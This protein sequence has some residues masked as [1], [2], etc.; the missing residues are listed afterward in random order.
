MLEKINF[1]YDTLDFDNKEPYRVYLDRKKLA[2]TASY[3][4][5]EEKTTFDISKEYN[6]SVLDIT[7]VGLALPDGTYKDLQILNNKVS[8]YGDW[9]T[10]NVVM[11]VPYLFKATLSPIY[12]RKA[13][14]NGSTEAVTNGRLQLRNIKLNYS[15]T[16]GFVVN[17]VMSTGKT[18]TYSMTGRTLGAPSALLGRIA[19]DTGVFRIPVQAQNTQCAVSI[20]SD[21]PLPLSLVGFIWEGNFVQTSKGV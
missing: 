13:D 17:V 8:I 18:Y 14:N 15:N 9:T 6:D 4:A 3:D 20:V 7:R 5:L 11:G 21:M 16:G 1:T 2:V 10:S 12:I 19:M